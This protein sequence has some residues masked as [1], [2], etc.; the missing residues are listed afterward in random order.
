MTPFD[1]DEDIDDGNCSV[2]TMPP[3]PPRLVNLHK[4]HRCDEINGAHPDTAMHND[5]FPDD[6]DCSSSTQPL[7]STATPATPTSSANDTIASSTAS[8][9]GAKAGSSKMNRPPNGDN[10]RMDNINTTCEGTN[11]SGKILDATVT[12]LSL[13]GMVASERKNSKLQK[14]LKKRAAPSS[15]D[16]GDNSSRAVNQTA[17]MVA[18]FAQSVGSKGDRVFLTHIPSSPVPL[19]ASAEAPS[20]TP[21]R[22]PAGASTH[23]QSSTS[24]SAASAT[25][26]SRVDFLAIC[27]REGTK[28]QAQKPSR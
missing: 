13:H 8:S 21:T 2:S 5:E 11:V 1:D 10:N 16:G 26:Y 6:T 24:S 15:N 25:S 19:A 12:V 3:S 28:G 22:G 4:Q 27:H 17:T 14:K 23:P 9:S 18:S 7:S 20:S